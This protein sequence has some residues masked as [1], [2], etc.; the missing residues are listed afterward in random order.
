MTSHEPR[1]L[2]YYAGSRWFQWSVVCLVT[3]MLVLGLL[4]ALKDVEARAERQMVDLTI[5]NMRTGMQLAMGEALMHQREGE[6]AG[7]AGS[8]PVRWLERPPAGYRGECSPISIK[9][10]DQG[11]WCFAP[12]SGNLFYKLR[13]QELAISAMVSAGECRLLSWRVER[14]AAGLKSDSFAGLRLVALG[15]CRRRAGGN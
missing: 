2:G 15:P 7:W 3:G 4:S 10:L 6:I 1:T 9:D 14:N 11:I 13:N 5:R 8:N 12:E